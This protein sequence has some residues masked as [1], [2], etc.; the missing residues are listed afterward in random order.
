M[1]TSFY[2]EYSTNNGITEIALSSSLNKYFHY[3][4]SSLNDTFFS[5]GI[6]YDN[7][8]I[9]ELSEPS[10]K[11][12]SIDGFNFDLRYFSSFY[13]YITKIF[14]IILIFEPWYI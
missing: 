4:L 14:V 3:G 5:E 11:Y 2:D 8:D 7:I 10:K 9:N 1:L 13:L 6:F 12:K